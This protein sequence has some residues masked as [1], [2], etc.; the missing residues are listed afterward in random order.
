MDRLPA[1]LKG[2]QPPEDLLSSVSVIQTDILGLPELLDPSPDPGSLRTSLQPSI[3]LET[4]ENS[5][6]NKE[7]EQTFLAED[8]VGFPG[9]Q[10]SDGLRPKKTKE[11]GGGSES[12]V[13]ES[14]GL[15]HQVRMWT[16]C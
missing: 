2:I 3:L 11:Q 12:L 13:A 8:S 5:W 15:T 9:T 14:C 16:V 6:N 4:L 10:A 1:R 7:V